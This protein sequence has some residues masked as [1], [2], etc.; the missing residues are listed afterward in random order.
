MNPLPSYPKLLFDWTGVG[1]GIQTVHVVVHRAE[2]IGG[3]GGVTAKTRLQNGIMDKDILLLKER[4]VQLKYFRL[5]PAF[6]FQLKHQYVQYRTML[7]LML[8][9]CD[10]VN[11]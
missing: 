3:N 9:E 10:V 1:L 7:L 5:S 6:Q 4:N 11:Y 2:L 8:D